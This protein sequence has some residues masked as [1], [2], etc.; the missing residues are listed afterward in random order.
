MKTNSTKSLVPV[1]ALTLIIVTTLIAPMNYNAHAQT[2]SINLSIAKSTYQY[3]ER[4][5]YTVSVSE[6]TGQAAIVHIIDQNQKSSNA[7]P[8]PIEML[9]NEIK[10]PF[11]FERSIFPTGAYT[12]NMT[13]SG[14]QSTASFEIVDGDNICIPSQV[15]QIVA[16]WMTG[17]VSDGFLID[18]IK[19]SVDAKLIEVPFEIDQENIYNITIPEWV[20][21]AAYWWIT[22]EITDDTMSSVFDYLLKM[23]VI[24]VQ[25]IDGEN[26]QLGPSNDT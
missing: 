4:L 1:F 3:C 15:R 2:P 21:T 13:Y 7:I 18:V 16:A 14:A 9:E 17:A 20:K 6:V 23:E 11:P 8:I 19:K 25:K 10:A 5:S 26:K 22:D 24:G 12:I